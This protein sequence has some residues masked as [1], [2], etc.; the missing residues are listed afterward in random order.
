MTVDSILRSKDRGVI[1]VEADAA[2]G[3]TLCLMRHKNISA[4]VVSG[5]GRDV[6]GLIC[7]R[8]LVRALK[9]H[10]ATSLMSLTVAEIMRRDVAT[11]RP[12]EGLRNVMTRMISQR[13]HHMPVVNA[14]G[15][16]GI[17]SL[18]EIM[19]R[20]L[21]DAEFEAAQSHMPAA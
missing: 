13:L 15:V 11:C 17:I 10:G 3:A 1:T 12:E 20:R 19:K 2:V 4:V 16:C 7:E 18:A 9:T 14:N 5:T 8:E 6:E 21:R